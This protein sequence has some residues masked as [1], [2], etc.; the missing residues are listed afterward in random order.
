MIDYLKVYNLP[1]SAKR[2]LNN[3]LLTFPLS[4]VATTGE[5]LNRAQIAH[6]S[7]LDISVKGENVGLKGSI[8]KYYEGGTNYK[9]FNL[10]DIRKVIKE[11]AG[12][13]DFDLNKSLINF[14]EI[15]VNIP[16]DYSPTKLIKSLI[17]YNN[18][19]FQT[20]PTKGEGYGRKCE[21]QRFIIKAYNKSLQYSLPYHLLRFEVKVIRMQH[22]LKYGIKHLTLADLTK[23]DL[24]PKLQKML[25]DTL[26]GILLYNPILTPDNFN[27]QNDRELFMEGRHFDYWQEMDK[28]KRSRKQ[29]RFSELAGTKK[30][31]ASLA[32]LIEKK[33]YQLTTFQNE[34]VLPINHISEAIEKGKVLPFNTTIDRYLVTH[35]TVTS[36]PIH[37]QKSGSKYLSSKGIKWYYVNKP[38]VYKTKLEILLTKKWKRKHLNK[39]KEYYFHE[40]YHQIRNRANNPHNNP[41]NNTK[42]SYMNIKRKGLLLFPLMETVAPA[43]LELMNTY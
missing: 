18:H 36:L 6:Y 35:C 34:K 27:N 1:I 19:E 23:Q 37:N 29:K 42:K 17:S 20:L 2:V 33:C 5:V 21:T 31:K 11:L 28:M 30:V 25:L 16:L 38:E 4:N 40:I 22:L 43:K 10:L 9:D 3:P 24:Y 15:G 13:F 26:D 32:K 8:H 41:R 12:K 14:I 39:S 7:N